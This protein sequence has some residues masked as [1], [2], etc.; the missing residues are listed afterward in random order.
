MDLSPVYQPLIA[1]LWYL[2][3]LAIIAGLVKSPWFK[4]KFGEFLVNLS[5]RWFLDK[6]R[7]HLIKNVTL[8]T[9]DG[10]TQ[11]DHVLVSEFGVFVVETKN[12]KG[13]IFGGPHQR[14][15]TQKIYRSNHKFPA[16][17]ARDR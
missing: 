4:G 14:S 12:M 8:S 6:S 5:V 13:W 2:L 17:A 15:W 16:D 11:I 7:Y 3:P 1:A 9:E 10:T